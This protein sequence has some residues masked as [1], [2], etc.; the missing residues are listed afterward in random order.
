MKVSEFIQAPYK[1]LGR[2]VDHP[3]PYSAEVKERVELYLYSSSG[4][5]WP[6]IGWPLPLPL[7]YKPCPA[8]G[9]HVHTTFICMINF[10]VKFCPLSQQPHGLWGHPPLCSMFVGSLCL[11][12]KRPW[13]EADYYLK[14]SWSC[15]SIMPYVFMTW[16]LLKHRNFIFILPF[17]SSNRLITSGGFL[18]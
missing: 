6:V 4:P 15:T 7:P 10:G 17:V 9:C 8:I 3:P 18:R 11:G 13:R 16:C 5:S 12:T 2:G 1:R 14:N